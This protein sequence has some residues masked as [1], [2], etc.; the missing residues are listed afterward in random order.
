MQEWDDKECREAP[1]Q[2][3]EAQSWL[4][5]RTGI[6]VNLKKNPLTAKLVDKVTIEGVIEL[7][8]ELD[9]SGLKRVI[10]F[11]QEELE[12]KSK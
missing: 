1:E 8:K 7:I 4:S 10:K 3:F 12:R 5:E 11:S 9:V 6:H 2:D